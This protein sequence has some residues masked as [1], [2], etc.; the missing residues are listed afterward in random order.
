MILAFLV[1][2]P[3]CIELAGWFVDAT[4]VSRVINEQ[5]ISRDED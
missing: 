4:F 2:L 3:L 1:A 5:R